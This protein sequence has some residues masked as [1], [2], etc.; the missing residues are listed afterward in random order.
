MGKK[1]AGRVIDVS[2]R[3]EEIRS[4]F[5]ADL[6]GKGALPVAPEAEASLP[7]KKPAARKAAEARPAVLPPKNGHETK[8]GHAETVEM[9]QP[10]SAAPQPG[11]EK[12]PPRDNSER[13]SPHSNFDELAA[14][15][16][17]LADATTRATSAYWAPHF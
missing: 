5:Q 12:P 9:P 1:A 4:A 8:N 3:D 17:R 7:R 2:G 11:A 6:R 16:G 10:P 13:P 14:N 15:L